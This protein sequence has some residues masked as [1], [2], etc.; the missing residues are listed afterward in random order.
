MEDPRILQIL[1]TLPPDM[2]RS[3]LEMSKSAVADPKVLE[4]LPA[5]LLEMLPVQTPPLG[6]QSNFVDPASRV[7]VILGIGSTF[8]ALALLCFI[9]RVYTKIAILKKWRW[10]DTTCTIG[11]VS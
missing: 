9:I 4:E 5:E 6:I 10:D 11:F 2:L 7:P 8:F 3:L 1:G